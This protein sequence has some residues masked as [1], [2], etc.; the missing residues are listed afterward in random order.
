MRK[1]LPSEST[2]AQPLYPRVLGNEWS[3]V[4]RSVQ[5]AHLQGSRLCGEGAVEFKIGRTRYAAALRPLLRLPRT[6]TYQAR[7][8]VTHEGD[9]EVWL[10]SFGSHR[11]VTTQM[12]ISPGIVRERFRWFE[13]DVAVTRTEHGI[14]YNSTRARL[15]AGPIAIPLPTRF[16]PKIDA[17]EIPDGEGTRIDVKVLFPR[18]R[19]LMSYAGRFTW[20]HL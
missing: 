13:F 9:E 20:R 3:L 18:D 12:E 1:V 6:G 5:S 15:R 4:S 7:V 16:S 11:V 19:V 10:R 14:C 2:I 17:T 8:E